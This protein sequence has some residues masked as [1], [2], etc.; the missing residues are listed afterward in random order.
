MRT[1]ALLVALVG[2]V[3]PVRAPAAQAALVDPLQ[4]GTPAGEPVA[5]LGGLRVAR[6]TLTLDLRPLGARL[7][8][9]VRFA[10]VEAV[11]GVVNDGA[12]RTW[13]V[14]LV[15]LGSDAEA[16][17]VWLDGQAVAAEPVAGFA[18][19][20][21]WTGIRAAPDFDGDQIP[22][23]AEAGAARG[24]RFVLAIGP[25]QH[26]VRVRT[27]VRAGSYDDG[28]QANRTWQVAY[29]LAPARLWP[30]FGQLDVAVLAPEGWEMATSLPMRRAP[31]GEGAPG[32]E[33][34]VARF[35]GVPGD[36]LAVSVRAPEPGG[37]RALH[38]FAFAFA[39]L[40][41]GVFGALGGLAAARLGRP[42]RWALPASLLG[43]V[44]AAATLLALRAVADGLGDSD[45]VGVS[46]LV[47][48]VSVLGPAVLVLGAA[49]AQAVAAAVARRVPPARPS[50]TFGPET[51]N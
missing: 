4:P 1:A 37:R 25:G 26:Q 15:A 8:S 51:L 30:G 2:L 47:A 13:P 7:S 24:L 18:V 39:A 42:A 49:L 40:V 31:G 27:R 10:T 5:A 12:A 17:Q 46:S 32:A 48:S 20:A 38:A 23:A 9:S 34:A 29:S 22:Y 36:V 35:A 14:E 6:E 3:A 43:G 16:A 41:A 45:A 44:A 11:Y 21:L 28:G 33:R 50:H 19:P